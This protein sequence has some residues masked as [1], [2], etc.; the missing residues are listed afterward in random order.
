MH[1]QGRGM[2]TGKNLTGSM[3]MSDY[4]VESVFFT[5]ISSAETTEDV[6]GRM[7]DHTSL[8]PGDEQRALTDP[9]PYD[10]ETR[11]V[12]ELRAQDTETT[13]QTRLGS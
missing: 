10:A 13:R 6:R 8:L 9:D 3:R 2:D 5:T 1:N 11:P 4:E 12:A 7:A